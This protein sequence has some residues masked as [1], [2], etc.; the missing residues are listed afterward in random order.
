[1]NIDD[2]T[3]IYSPEMY[4][5]SGKGWYAIRKADDKVSKRFETREQL[6]KALEKE[7]GYFC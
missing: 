1:M 4:L 2:Y 6:V 7:K 5:Q 3:I